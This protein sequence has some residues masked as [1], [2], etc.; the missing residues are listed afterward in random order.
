MDDCQGWQQAHIPDGVEATDVAVLEDGHDA[1][2][3]CY[4]QWLVDDISVSN[5]VHLDTCIK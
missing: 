3:M 2:S 4:K 5:L 1:V